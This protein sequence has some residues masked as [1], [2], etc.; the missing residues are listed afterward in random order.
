[1]TEMIGCISGSL[2]LWYYTYKSWKDSIG[3]KFWSNT[4]T[5]YGS[6]AND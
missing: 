5:E 3:W 2:M 1:M 6:P 4:V